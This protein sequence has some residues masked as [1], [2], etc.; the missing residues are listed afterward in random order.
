MPVP[1]QALPSPPSPPVAPAQRI[2]QRADPQSAMSAGDESDANIVVTGS[3]SGN[4]RGNAAAPPSRG[5]IAIEP[6][7]ADR[8]YLA[9]LDAAS[10]ADAERVFAAQQAEHGALPAF[11]LD[12]AD[13]AWRK[14]DRRRAVRL[15]LSALEL[16]TRDS[17]TLSIVAE[18]L[19]RYGEVERAVSLLERLAA[20]EDDRPQP[21]R[22]LA[23]ALARRAEGAPRDRARADLGR[24]IALLTE[25][26]M[27][28]WNNAYDGIEMIA[29]MEANRLIPRY[30]ALGGT[31]LPLDRR[32]IALLDTDIRVVIEWQTDATDIDL[33]VDEP[34]GERAYFG[35]Q[36]TRIGGHMSNDM[37]QGYGPEEYFLRTAPL[38]SYD[39]RANIYA[40]DRIDPNG[41]QRVT[42]RLIRDWGRPNEREEVVD[43]EVLPTDDER[44]RRV[45]RL[46]F[47][48]PAPRR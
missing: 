10:P 27:T 36:R 16:P 4:G 18:R 24:A 28:P 14:G 25:V 1:I 15:L 26:V 46:V 22:S 33:W 45:G 48:A 35:N 8:P 42:A 34:G 39:V 23:L 19:L 11:W 32:L 7:K 2:E 13:W 12:V 30:R 21:R 5:A 37:T 3:S 47:G 31:E 40:S 17:A 43:I 44:E 41:A 6:W 29:L 38:G 20:A 9:A